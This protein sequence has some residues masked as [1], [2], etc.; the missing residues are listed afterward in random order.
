MSVVRL[1]A[2]RVQTVEYEINMGD[3]GVQEDYPG[4]CNAEELATVFKADIENDA[5]YVFE[6]SDVDDVTVEVIFG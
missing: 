6:S 3:E 1:Q 4:V 5:D 2:T